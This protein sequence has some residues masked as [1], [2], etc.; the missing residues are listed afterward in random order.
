MDDSIWLPAPPGPPAP[1]LADFAALLA[2]I[3]SAL[4][5]IDTYDLPWP[6]WQFLAYA[7]ATGRFALHGTGAD[8]ILKFEP[9]QSNDAAE[10]GN[11][12]GVY[13]AADA[14]WP[15]YF[16][17]V[18]RRKV[19]SLINACF[20]VYSLDGEYRSGPWYFFS[21]G[22]A[23]LAPWRDG[24]VYLLPAAGF[25]RQEDLIRGDQRIRPSQLYLPSSVRPVA[26]IPVRPIDFPMLADIR[27]HDWKVIQARTAADPDGFPWLED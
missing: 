23:D 8:P 18:D 21:V 16:A 2:R 9:R 15:M 6:V 14:L 13:A 5:P 25:E 10:F 19:P 11:R 20:S 26:R 1:A 24:A 3:D 4:D 7:A 22:S 17:I 27:R 12:R